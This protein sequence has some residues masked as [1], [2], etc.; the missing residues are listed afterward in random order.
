MSKVFV[1]IDDNPVDR[2]LC[3]RYLKRSGYCNEKFFEVGTAEE[4][5]AICRK[6]MPDCI[7]LDY[8]LPDMSGLEFIDELRHL[9][10]KRSSALIMMT[11][12]GDESVAAESIKRNIDAYLI[13]NEINEKIII[14]SIEHAINAKELQQHILEQNFQLE[15][16]VNE[17]PLTSL[18]NRSAFENQ[19]GKALSQ[20][21]R[22]DRKVGFL[23]I[24]IDNF[25][26]VNDSYGHDVG[27]RVLQYVS[28][29]MRFRTRKED[30]LA[31]IGGD[32]FMLILLDIKSSN[33]AGL[34]ADN[35]VCDIS[36]PFVINNINIRLSSSI[37]IAIFPLAGQ[38]LKSL[39]KAAD[40]ALYEAKKQG[41][42]CFQF[43]TK[44]LN[45]E[46]T[47]HVRV[48]H[49]L[50]KAIEVNSFDLVFQPQICI[51]TNK[52]S[53]FEVLLR[54]H[55]A[56]LGTVPT[57]EFISI[58][59]ERNL[60]VD[61]GHCVLEKTCKYMAKLIANNEID[62]DIRFAIN[63]SPKELLVSGFEDQIESVTN[64][65]KI[66]P[67]RI[68]LEI[69]ESAIMESYQAAQKKLERLNQRGFR[70]S[71]D[72]F[73]TGYSSLSRL[74]TMPVHALKIDRVFIDNLHQSE[75]NKVI[76][77]SILN[78][79]ENLKLNVVAEGVETEE[80]L[81]VLKEFKCPDAQGYYYSKPL[82][83][84]EMKKM[85]KNDQ[86]D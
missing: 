14:S 46:Y 62:D 38:D 77:K 19:A 78:I 58:A 16:L 55:D 64:K 35:I 30:I 71:I 8:N 7:I 41:K 49:Y 75:P 42:E 69:T 72:D 6:E 3:L 67:K 12:Q 80:D 74:V 23:L 44:Q 11:G 54:W 61:I 86:K 60:I 18:F 34:V 73:G 83:P 39:M 24:D 22:H 50:K 29:K 63:V 17:D 51:E 48:E 1:I 56:E 81:K 33:D 52:I 43:F 4:G 2:E 15:I 10:S 27:D 76:V 85:L 79:A 9:D 82:Q 40:L 59:E 25:K 70:I 28:K 65:Y 31:R 21:S 5:L 66:D 26:A 37:G 47:R 20:A 53:C 13:K 68:E 57:D 36:K 45:D 32:E 84:A